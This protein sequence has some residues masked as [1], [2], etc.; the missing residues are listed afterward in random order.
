MREAPTPLDRVKSKALQAFLG[1]KG[2]DLGAMCL[3]LIGYEGSAGHAASQRKLTERIVKQHGGVGIGQSPGRLYDQKKFDTPYIRDFLLDRGAP[4]DVSETSAPWSELPTVYD[5]VM[6]AGH[7]ALRRLG[8]PGYLMCHLSHSYH[9]GACLYFTFA[10][11]PPSE[12]DPLAQYGVVKRAIQQAF[13][14]S[15]GHAVPSPCGR[16]RARPVAGGGHIVVR[17]GDAAG[18]VR[19]HRSRGESQPGEDRCG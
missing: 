16:H 12:R 6:A 10:L 8:V 3:S 19:G 17:C 13:V 9:A 4:A 14:D 2:W 15:G 1:R 7:G 5:N 11:N 18:A